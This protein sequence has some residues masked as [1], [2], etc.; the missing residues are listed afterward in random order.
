MT[1]R[2]V[3]DSDKYSNYKTTR[4]LTPACTTQ[5]CISAR[6]VTRAET[7]APRKVVVEV[8]V[9]VVVMLLLDGGGWLQVR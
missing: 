9:M 7:V 4:T 1:A 6:Y 5:S 8:V 3:A 2:L